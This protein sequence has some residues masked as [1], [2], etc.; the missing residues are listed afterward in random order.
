MRHT[1]T[2]KPLKNLDW[3]I[4]RLERIEK[5]P[6]TRKILKESIK[7]LILS[8]I[9]S[10]IGGI[11][12]EAA[13]VKLFA[14]LPFLIMLPALNDMIGDFGTIVASKFTVLLYQKR[15]KRHEWWKGAAVHHLFMTVSSVALI[16]SL[17][18]ATLAYAIAWI[19][20]FAFEPILFAKL[21]GISLFATLFLVLIIFA[22]SII[23]GLYVHKKGHDPDNYLIP[24][25]TGIADFGSMLV[26]GIVLRWLF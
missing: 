8:S 14:L 3:P 1:P 10:S 9:I 4:N 21:V 20:G 19:R 25:A 17:F 18:M 5:E 11:S 13:R 26:L 15:I 16:A 12:I 22:V 24:L 2:E 7:I 23:G 6:T